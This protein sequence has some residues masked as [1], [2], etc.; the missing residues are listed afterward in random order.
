MKN[1]T[2]IHQVPDLTN[3]PN[4]I[5]K[6]LVELNHPRPN[7]WLRKLDSSVFTVTD[8]ELQRYM[9]NDALRIILGIYTIENTMEIR[10]CLINKGSIEEWLG[11]FKQYIG[12]SL[13]RLNLPLAIN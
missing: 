6:I 10:Y 1:V 3:L 2:Y 5:T 9:I 11:L 12:P 13:V 7:D 8:P 4:E